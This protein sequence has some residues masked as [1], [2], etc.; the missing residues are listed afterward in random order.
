MRSR[1]P[2]PGRSLFL[3]F[4]AAAFG[5]IFMAVPLVSSLESQRGVVAFAPAARLASAGGSASAG[6]SGA[7]PLQ[8]RQPT[9]EQCDRNRDGL[10]DK[11]EAASVQGLSAYFERGDVNRDGRLDKVEFARA[12]GQLDARRP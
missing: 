11:S 12:L 5:A 7:A 2:R 9:F 10:L 1:S 6:S 4:M 3:L 8:A